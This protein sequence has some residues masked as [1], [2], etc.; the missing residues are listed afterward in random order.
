VND[1]DREGRK[2][3]ALH[4]AIEID[5]GFAESHNLSQSDIVAV[6][7]ANQT[8][9]FFPEFGFAFNGGYRNFTPIPLGIRGIIVPYG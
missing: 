8:P 5:E 6:H 1:I 3:P 9:V 2:I 7:R 4:H